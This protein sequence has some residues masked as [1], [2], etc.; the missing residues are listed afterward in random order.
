LARPAREKRAAK[1]PRQLAQLQADSSAAAHL[2]RRG[3][4]VVARIERVAPWPG[5]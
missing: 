1:T 2:G 4:K 5:R 3:L